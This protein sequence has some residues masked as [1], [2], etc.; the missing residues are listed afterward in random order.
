MSV[1]PPCTRTKCIGLGRCHY[2]LHMILSW[3]QVASTER[4]KGHT[5][6]SWPMSSAKPRCVGRC[7][8]DRRDTG[9]LRCTDAGTVLGPVM[10]IVDA[11]RLGHQRFEGHKHASAARANAHTPTPVDGMS[12][13]MFESSSPIQPHRSSP[14]PSSPITPLE[15]R[16]C[17]PHPTR[18]RCRDPPARPI[19]SLASRLGASPTRPRPPPPRIHATRPRAHS[20]RHR[21]QHTTPLHNRL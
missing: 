15:P 12:G 13:S 1:S 17:N 5:P 21:F 16:A 11:T 4:R 3:E 10:G 19:S 7:D 20:C 6:S 14:D 8:A 18:S 9:E 2:Q